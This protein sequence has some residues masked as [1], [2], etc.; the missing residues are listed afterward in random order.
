MSG[1]ELARWAR[2]VTSNRLIPVGS[3]F[4][5]TGNGGS[6]FGGDLCTPL[7]RLLAALTQTPHVGGTV[8]RS[9]SIPLFM[10][11]CAGLAAVSLMLEGGKHAKPPVSRC[12]NKRG[13]ALAILRCMGLRPGQGAHHYLWCEPDPGVRL[14]LEAYRDPELARAAAEVIRGWADEEPRA[15]WERLRAEGPVV[16]TTPREVGRWLLVRW[17]TVGQAPS[18][19]FR[20]SAGGRW[21]DTPPK[22][23]TLAANMPKGLASPATILRDARDVDPARVPPGTVAYVDPSYVG[24]TGYEDNLTRDEVCAMAERWASAGALVC[25]SEAEPIE[26]LG[27]HT[28]EITSQRSGQKRTFSKQQREWLTMSQPPRW[29]PAVQHNLFGPATVDTGR[30]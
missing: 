1:R 24:T 8:P 30:R 29:K 18:G 12:G 22:P 4:R 13:Y 5:N 20:A 14:L 25:I 21:P 10:E 28:V 7:P 6:T 17:Q 26:E 15:L 3:D 16:D 23:R 19:G 27:W 2:I 9:D 11:L